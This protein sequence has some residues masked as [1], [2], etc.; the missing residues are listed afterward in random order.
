MTSPEIRVNPAEAAGTLAKLG[1]QFA[2]A[3]GSLPLSPSGLDPSVAA[4]VDGQVNNSQQALNGAGE[5]SRNG[6]AGAEALGDQ[7]RANSNR[8]GKVDTDLKDRAGAGRGDGL[9]RPSRVDA[10]RLSA[11]D[12]AKLTGAGQYQSPMPTMQTAPSSPSMPSIPAMPMSGASAPI[13]SM[14]GPAG[15]LSPLLGKLMATGGPAS[16]PMGAALTGKGGQLQELVRG[17]LGTPYAWG[18]GALDGPS[19]GISDG[20]GPADRAGDYKK[21]G[22]DCS[23]LSRYLTYQSTG[24][25]IPRT[26]E[27]QYAAGVPV[28]AAQARPGDLFFPNSAGRPPGHV[29]VYIGNNQVVEAPSSGQTV[30]I[31]P[32]RPGEFRRMVA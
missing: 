4:A 28:S 13:Q 7:D 17:T 25:E 32:L 26:S 10:P 16:Q 27:A 11:S 24:H 6:K 8:A 9:G 14:L 19:Q 30:K 22:F 18:G 23:G 29:Q 12:L 3:G 1:G 21:I 31:S 5:T 2:A 15:A 20:G